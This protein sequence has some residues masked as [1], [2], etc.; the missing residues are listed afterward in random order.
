[1][2]LTG[3]QSESME[4]LYSSVNNAIMYAEDLSMD[5]RIKPAMI[6]FL[7]KLRWIKTNIDIRIPADRRKEAESRDTLFYDEL[8]RMATLLNQEQKDKLEEFLKTI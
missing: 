6:Q 2:K 8:L 5:G 3:S 7:N 1:M 4:L